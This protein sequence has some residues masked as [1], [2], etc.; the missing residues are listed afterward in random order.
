MDTPP[1]AAAIMLIVKTGLRIAY[2]VGSGGGWKRKTL[3]ILHC[4]VQ[5]LIFATAFEYVG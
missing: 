1:Q 2:F 3:E 4:G 5:M